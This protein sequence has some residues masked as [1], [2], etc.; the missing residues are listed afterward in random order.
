MEVRNVVCSENAF[1]NASS[2]MPDELYYFR[3][4]INHLQCAEIC[5][6][7]E[8]KKALCVKRYAGHMD[9]YNRYASKA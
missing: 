4:N 3:A 2:T 8:S 9:L 1:L 7:G 5:M 6:G